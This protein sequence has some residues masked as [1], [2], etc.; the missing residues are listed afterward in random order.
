MPRHAPLYEWVAHVATR[1]PDLPAAHARS[2]GEW[3]YGMAVT[4]AVQLTAVAVQLA[5]L[6][7][8]RVNTVRQRLR[9]LFQPGERKA[10]DRRTTF[11]PP[12][13]CGP[14]VRWVTDGWTDRR[15]ALALDAS[16]L[17]DRFT[18]LAAAIVYRGV[19]IPVAWR[20]LPGGQP[21]ESWNA[22]W[23]ELVG[24]V[25]AAVGD[26]WRVFVLTARGLESAAL[27]R[28][29]VTA[30]CHPLMRAK[31]GGTFRPAGWVRWRAMGQFAGR[32]GD[33]FAARGTAYKTSEAPLGCT[34]LACR[35]GGCADPWLILTDLP[36][37]AAD[38]CWYAFRSWIEQ[39]FRLVKRGGWQWQRTRMSDPSRV[40]RVWAAVAVATVWV[41]EVGGLAEHVERAE[42]MPPVPAEVDTPA[43]GRRGRRATGVRSRNRP[44]TRR[45]HRVFGRGLAAV[46]AGL[47]NGQVRTGRFI[48]EPWP[49]VRRVP[50]LTEAEFDARE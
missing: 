32:E 10:G 24:R 12:A 17:G 8:Q 37:G 11:H 16:N 14:L 1:F 46:V 48:P 38:P 19:G 31:S 20:V 36:P 35:V 49:T 39:G 41:V 15:M 9:E 42:T 28:H 33:R 3:S 43:T 23:V 6:V 22:V 44:G 26:D 47:L 7:G 40:E 2:L 34:L 4:R 27:F 18:V 13:C 5:V 29:L 25:R 50:R 45:A 30:G 21:G